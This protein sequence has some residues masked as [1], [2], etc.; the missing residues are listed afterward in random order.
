MTAMKL[1][2]GKEAAYI[3][4][5]VDEGTLGHVYYGWSTYLRGLDG[6][7]MRPTFTRKS[8]SGGGA[9][10]DNGVHLLDLTWYLMGC[11]DPVSVTGMTDLSYA[12]IG[13]ANQ[14]RVAEAGGKD[15]F[16]VETFGCGMIRF[17]NG[18]ATMLDNGWSTFVAEP[19]FSVRV[20]GTEGGAT[21]LPF[22]FVRE[23]DGAAVSVAPDPAT[24]PEE[25]QFAHFIRCIREGNEPLSTI[26]QGVRMVRMLDALYESDR[27]AKSVAVGNG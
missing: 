3:R 13:A 25:T 15:V 8:V 9:I 23:H 4:R 26:E 16:D 17:A 6:V 27:T 24:L 18:A 10:I 7:P 1:R 22:T 2:F 14:N 20:L 12:P 11:P 5:E 21:L 19:T